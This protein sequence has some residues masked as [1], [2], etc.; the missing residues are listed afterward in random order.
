MQT[1]AD[2]LLKIAGQQLSG[3]GSMSG[4]DSGDYT[5]SV[6]RPAPILAPRCRAPP[7]ALRGSGVAAA[8]C[9]AAA[10]DA[11]RSL[12]QNLLHFLQTYTRI[13]SYV[14]FGMAFLQARLHPPGNKDSPAPSGFQP[15]P[16]LRFVCCA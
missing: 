5:N 6:R 13:L 1:S 15:S 11:S 10:H 9:A 4:S 7:S 12:A 2:K 16:L 8:P 3:G 14:L